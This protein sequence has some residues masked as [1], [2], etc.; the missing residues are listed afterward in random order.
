M[1]QSPPPEAIASPSDPALDLFLHHLRIERSLSAHT[2]DA[3]GAD[4]REYLASPGLGAGVSGVTRDAIGAHL[5][6][7]HER[8]LSERSQARHLAAIRAFHRFL[9]AE[10]LCK[11]DPSAELTAPRPP[12]GLPRLLSL[13]EVDR[14]LAAPRLDESLEGRRDE[15]MLQLLY[16]CGLRVSELAGLPTAALNLTSGVVL[17]RGKGGKERVV[18][19][20]EAA[21]RAVGDYLETTRPALLGARQSP[22][23]FVT[24]RGRRMTRQGFWKRLAAHARAAGIAR[25]VSPHQL[26]HS[27]ATH[28]LERGADLRAVQAMLGHA[29]I[30]TTQIY[31]H[32]DG[33][34]LRAVYEK[35]HPRA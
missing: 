31:T 10:R 17:V 20:H 7:L 29:D 26:R 18:P 23:L 21:R 3:Y 27:F 4:L 1:R 28:L 11:D 5:K 30:S 8:G 9:A 22:D 19:V 15:A 16:A 14:L 33:A 13:D 35:A 25:P 12:R 6:A 24:R 2:V 34:R 32:V